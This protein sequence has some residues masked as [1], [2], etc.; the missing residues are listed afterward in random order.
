LFGKY[1]EKEIIEDPNYI[2]KMKLS[3]C[4]KHERFCHILVSINIFT[5]NLEGSPEEYLYFEEKSKI[6]LVTDGKKESENAFKYLI[7]HNDDFLNF[8]HSPPENINYEQFFN[9]EIW[10]DNTML[11]LYYLYRD[12]FEENNQISKKN[13]NRK[14]DGNNASKTLKICRDNYCDIF[15][16][17][18][19]LS[20]DP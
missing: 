3:L 19:K 20:K 9:F 5:G 2:N 8:L 11:L 1:L 18:K 16:E 4:M 13:S 15:K 12:Y 6:M 17:E 14:K 7:S 10:I